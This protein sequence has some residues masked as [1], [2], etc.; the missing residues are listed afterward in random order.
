MVNV[1]NFVSYIIVNLA[2]S[3]IFAM[4]GLPHQAAIFVSITVWGGLAF[5]AYHFYFRRY[6]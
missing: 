6:P 4:V 5:T 2:I 1:I 3:V